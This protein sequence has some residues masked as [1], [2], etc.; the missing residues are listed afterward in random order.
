MQGGFDDGVGDGLDGLLVFRE[1]FL[2]VEALV[3]GDDGEVGGD[4]EDDAGVA[5]DHLGA[6]DARA[7]E[8]AGEA[9]GDV[10]VPGGEGEVFQ[11]GPG[12][13]G[14]WVFDLGV[15]GGIV[16]EDVDAAELRDDADRERVRARLRR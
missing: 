15:V 10:G 1:A 12:L 5:L 16:D 7:E 9:D 4:V 3:G 2:A 14:L 6:E 8:G 13:A 11:A